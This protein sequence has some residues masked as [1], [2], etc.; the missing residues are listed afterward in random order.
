[1]ISIDSS[2]VLIMVVDDEIINL[3]IIESMLNIENFR[4]LLVSNPNEVIEKALTNQPDVILLDVSM[5][6]K[7]G[8]D[9]CRDLKDNPLTTK[10]PV[11]F[12]S[13]Q[14]SSE[15]VIK[16]LDSGA[17]D[18]IAKPF[19]APELL[20]RV[21]THI[22]LKIMVEK[23]IEMEQFKALHAAMVSQNHTL[24][25]LTASILGQVEIIELLEEKNETDLNKY[26]NAVKAIEKA[27]TE[28]DQMIKKFTNLSKVKFTKY[29]DKTDMLDLTNSRIEED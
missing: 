2:K 5:P 25:Q 14:Y 10:I 7:S 16:G 6:T 1:M 19:N 26:K 11:L 27:A 12:L 17:Q 24:N 3:K 8:F 23:L 20:A 18:Y 29:S 13:G 22:K 15:F 4:T 9:I 28:M 21:K